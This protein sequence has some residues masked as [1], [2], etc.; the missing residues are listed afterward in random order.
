MITLL[1]DFGN[2]DGFVGIMKGVI[3]N[4]S[5]SARVVDLS[6]EIEPQ[7]LSEAAFVLRNSFKFFPE[8]TVHVVV[9]DPGVGSGR[10]I[11]CVSAAGHL[12]LAPDNGVLKFIFADHPDAGVWEVT[13]KDYFLPEVSQTFHGRDIFSPVAA[14]LAKGLECRKLGARIRDYIKGELPKFE[15]TKDRIVGEVIYHDR[16]GNIISNIPRIRAEKEHAV[17]IQLKNHKIQGLAKSYAS[18][19]IDA[20]IALIGSS[21]FLEIAVNLGNARQSLNSKVGDEIVVDLKEKHE[22]G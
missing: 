6:H 3:L 5:P 8:G 4:I 19:K 18:G 9:V 10:R 1:T 16:F 22:K 2:R 21:G 11:V 14:Y 17:T 7:N 15:A 12:F 13:N 20:P